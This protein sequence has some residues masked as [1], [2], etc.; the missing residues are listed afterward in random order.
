[1]HEESGS[2]VISMEGNSDFCRYI[3]SI[4]D[5]RFIRIDLKSFLHKPELENVIISDIGRTYHALS[6]T[7][8]RKESISEIKNRFIVEMDRNQRKTATSFPI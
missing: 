6:I 4:E 2:N 1:M 7:D 8:K 5:T 3:S